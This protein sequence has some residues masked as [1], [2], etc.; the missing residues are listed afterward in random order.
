MDKENFSLLFVSLD[1][2][3][4]F[5]VD[6]VD[7]FGKQLA[8]RG[9]KI[10]W[11]LQ[12]EARCA[13]D[14]QTEY[15]G[16]TAWVGRTDAGK[17]RMARLRKHLYALSNDFKVL[18]IAT[19][20]DYDFVQV[21]DKCLAG[22]IAILAC[23]KRRSQFVYW[24]SWPFPEASLY[25]ARTGI[26]RYKYF[27]L[28][29]GAVFSFLLYKVVL[30][31][32]AHVFVQ[33]DQMMRD[34]VARGIRADRITPVPMGVSL[35]K[36]MPREEVLRAA[37]RA[38]GCTIVYLGVI[39]RTRKI[40]FL[41][42]VL[43][44]VRRQL[45]QARL[46]LVGAA[47][48]RAD[49]EWLEAEAEKLGER[50]NLRMTGFLPQAEAW[51]RVSEADVCV[52][53]FFPTPILLSTSPTKIVEYMALGKAVVANDHPDQKKV[54][55]E[56]GGGICVPYAEEAFAAALITIL[57]DRSM[58]REMGRKGRLYVE[59]TRDYV[60]LADLVEAKYLQLRRG[61]A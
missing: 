19:G 14:Y 2:Y 46:L 42:R 11:V 55:E 34:V 6:V 45:P 48:D 49:E 35:D 41:L 52:S 54:I 20:G 31:R 30:P 23:R 13:R 33:S 50:E 32:A 12:S 21:K 57:Q 7:L 53:P 8:G 29:R 27:Y 51:Q 47:H 17:S 28:L 40:D 4:A 61:G 24:L 36:M 44:L 22:L 59:Q 5:R 38:N 3:P 39:G 60:K 26:A 18:K 37:D 15:F 16:G 9:H 58:A 10:D 56:S 25:L 43:H 1:K